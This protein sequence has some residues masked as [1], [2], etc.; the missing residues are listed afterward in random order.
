MAHVFNSFKMEDKCF[1]PMSTDY[2]V[3][4]CKHLAAVS[5]IRRLFGFSA[6]ARICSTGE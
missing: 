2:S 3:F 6:I 1:C 4:Y 5:W